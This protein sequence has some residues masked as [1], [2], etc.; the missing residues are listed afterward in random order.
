MRSSLRKGC[1]Q[2]VQRCRG[3]THFL[4]FL[5]PSARF[6]PFCQVCTLLPGLHPSARFAPFCQ[7]C[8]LLPG[9]HPSAAASSETAK[10]DGYNDGMTVRI[11]ICGITT[12]PDATLAADLGADFIGLNFWSRSPRSISEGQAADIVRAIPSSVQPVALFVN[13]SM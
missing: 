8:T 12:P 5:H 4:H 7:V 1:M 11:K 2:K 3:D 13:E 6:A 9:L 10:C